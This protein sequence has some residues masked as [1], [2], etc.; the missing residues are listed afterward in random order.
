MGADATFSRF[1]INGEKTLLTDEAVPA[2]P[3]QQPSKLSDFFHGP[4]HC[5]CPEWRRS[6]SWSRISRKA[7]ESDRRGPAEYSRLAP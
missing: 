2:S 1:P 7:Y 3:L 5:R 6:G 4:I